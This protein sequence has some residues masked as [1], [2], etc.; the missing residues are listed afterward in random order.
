MAASNWQALLAYV[1]AFG[2][3]GESE[4]A[5]WLDSHCPLWR[6]G[7]SVEAHGRILLQH[8]EGADE[9]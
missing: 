9:A 4:A 3:L 1:M 2:G 7:Q 5:Q 8:K 6:E